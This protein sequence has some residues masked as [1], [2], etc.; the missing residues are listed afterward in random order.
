MEVRNLRNSRDSGVDKVEM[1]NELCGNG[2]AQGAN[3]LLAGVGV[4]EHGEFGV[5]K[6]VGLADRDGHAEPVSGRRD[7]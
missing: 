2:V 7:G 4:L 5:Q 3:G 6:F 1:A